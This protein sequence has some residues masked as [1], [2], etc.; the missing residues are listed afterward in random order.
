MFHVCV[1]QDKVAMHTAVL[2]MDEF[3][4]MTLP[5]RSHHYQTQLETDTL[6]SKFNESTDEEANFSKYLQ[7]SGVGSEGSRL[8]A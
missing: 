4:S 5:Q 7:G 3:R 6:L 2:N 1:I 8:E